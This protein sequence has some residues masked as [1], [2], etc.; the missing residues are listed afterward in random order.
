MAD[1]QQPVH[2]IHLAAEDFE[3]NLQAAGDKPVMVDFYAEW[4][5]PCKLAAPIMDKLSGEYADKAVIAKIDTDEEQELAMRF[6][7]QSI[8]TVI[9]FKNGKEIDRKIG[10][11]GE[12]GYRQMLD[13]AVAAQS[14]A[15]AA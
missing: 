1:T 3:Q 9:I 2:P 5:G 6:G 12:P 10:F 4:C 14:M 8:P 15:K 7:V 11:P 13:K